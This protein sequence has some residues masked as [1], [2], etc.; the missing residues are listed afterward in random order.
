MEA[1][2]IHPVAGS[3]PHRIMDTDSNNR[4]TWRM[5]MLRT[6]FIIAGVL[7]IIVVGAVYVCSKEEWF[8]IF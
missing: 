1:G 3:Y 8:E 2:K 4:E 7:T 6:L 5:V